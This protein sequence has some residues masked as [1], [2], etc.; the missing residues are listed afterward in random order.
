MSLKG[1]ESLSKNDKVPPTSPSRSLCVL[2]G[3]TCGIFMSSDELPTTIHA[4]MASEKPL[5]GATGSSIRYTHS[6]DPVGFRSALLC[7]FAFAL[8]SPLC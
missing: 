1:N 4:Q 7:H 8:F 3:L 2:E 5:C 6:I